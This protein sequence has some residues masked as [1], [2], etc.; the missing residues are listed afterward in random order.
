M[1][2]ALIATRHVV[3][4][5]P[6]PAIIYGNQFVAATT[7]FTCIGLAKRAA[8]LST[9]PTFSYQLLFST[10]AQPSIVDQLNLYY[11]RIINYLS[12]NANI[13]MLPSNL[14]LSNQIAGVIATAIPL[15]T[16]IQSLPVAAANAQALLVIQQKMTIALALLRSLAIP[17]TLNYS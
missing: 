13:T 16:I 4:P 7:T 17:I 15:N 6:P 3:P 14:Y 12:S 2:A 10:Q 9:N 11:Y 1:L 5:P 8:A